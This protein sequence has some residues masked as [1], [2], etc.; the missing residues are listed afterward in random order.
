MFNPGTILYTE[1]ELKT[2]RLSQ[3]PVTVWWRDGDTADCTGPIELV[4]KETVKINGVYYMIAACT[5][6]IC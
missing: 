5:F 6:E 2:A 4:D 3:Q 1:L